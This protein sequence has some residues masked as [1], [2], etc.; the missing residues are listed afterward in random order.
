MWRKTLFVALILMGV[1][2]AA[3]VPTMAQ[4]GIVWNAEYYNNTTLQG[5]PVVARQDS[6]VSFNWGSGSPASGVNA[7]NF[8]A[9]WGTDPFFQAG[10]YR[11]W[12]QADDKV[13]VYVDFGFQAIIDTF[14]NPAVGQIV[15]ADVTL[16]QGVHHIQVDYQEAAGDAYVYVTWANLATNPTGPN[17][18]PAGGNNPLPVSSGPWTAQYYANA[19]LSGTPT[20]IQTESNP[21]RDWGTGSPVASIPA[22]NWSARWTSVQTL[23]AGTYQI[24]VLADDGVRVTIDGVTYINEFHGATGNTY[25]ANVTLGAGQHSFLIEFYEAGGT[26]FLNYSFAPATSTSPTLVPTPS[27]LACATAT[28]TGAFRLNVRNAPSAINTTVLTKISRN[29]TYPIVGRNARGTWYQINVNGVVGWVN[30]RYVTANNA[31]NVPI[32]DGTVTNP[33][34]TPS[35]CTG[36]PTPRLVVGRTGRVL[37]GLPNNIRQQPSASSTRLG[38]IPPGGIFTVLS[39]PTCAGGYYWWQVNYNGIIGY[40]PEGG[41]GEYFLEPAS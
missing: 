17:F 21:S 22:D 30:A 25:K 10:T 5:P 31:A 7:D 15:S 24:T 39:A 34:V 27:C 1:L 4:S 20:L 29:E 37:P 9:R 11:F 40:T 2:G 8:S 6:A 33:T 23:N 18:P 14:A 16:A 3:V 36:A 28:V 41:N 35:T 13:R 19:T 12:V 38:Q 26:A 32:T